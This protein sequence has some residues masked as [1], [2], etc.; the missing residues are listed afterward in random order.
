MEG[1]DGA[2]PTAGA[3][4][5]ECE[6]RS[7]I[8]LAGGYLL[9]GSSSDSLHYHAAADSTSHRISR[10]SERP[11]RG[12]AHWPFVA[13]PR[14]PRP[15]SAVASASH[16]QGPGRSTTRRRPCLPTR[17]RT[18]TEAYPS[19]RVRPGVPGPFGQPRTVLPLHRR[20]QT[21]DELPFGRTWFDPEE[22]TRH[23][24]HHEV[25]LEY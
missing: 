10:P 23:P 8:C 22:P 20:Q 6:R 15:R 7:Y 14:S 13:L 17:L 19:H 9:R 11:G 2:S 1:V 18:A 3:F 25:L 24:R 5:T 21:G 4:L 12:V 16:L